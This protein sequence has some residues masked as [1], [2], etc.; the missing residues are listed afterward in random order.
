MK[1]RKTL[2]LFFLLTFIIGYSQNKTEELTTKEIRETI[3]EVGKVIKEKYVFPEIANAIVELINSNLRNGRYRSLSN[4]KELAKILTK[5]VQSINHDK[6]LRVFYNLEN[7]RGQQTEMSAEDREK[8]LEK[9]MEMEKRDNFTFKEV[10]IL[11]GNI[12][13]INFRGFRNP[14]YASETVIATMNFL[15]NTDAIIFDLRNNGG[16]YPQMVQLLSSYFFKGDAIHLNTFYNRIDETSEQFWTLPYVPG[17]RLPDV[18]LYILT[19][20]ST[21]SAAEEFSYNLKHLKRAMI[22]GETSGGGAHPGESFQVSNKFKVWTPTGRAI[23]P[24]TNSNW[25][26]VGVIPHIKTSEKDALISARLKALDSLKSVNT[27][28]FRNDFY[29][30]HM[31]TLKAV[32]TPVNVPL[33]SLEN[34]VG[35]YAELSISLENGVLYYQSDAPDSKVKLTPIDNSTF[36]YGELTD[37]RILFLRTNDQVEALMTKNVYG[38]SD[39]YTKDKN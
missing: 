19:G 20:S 7:P 13:Y 3:H 5:D 29:D 34:Y 9:M 33:S 22:I 11:D 2:I 17:K 30:W 36:Q 28:A 18:Q 24:I 1:K 10:K 15:S 16:G 37:V 12:G 27:D 21:F 25:E 14:E 39:T 35:T 26:G 38:R 32:Q 8:F 31:G 6:H 23:N 4:P